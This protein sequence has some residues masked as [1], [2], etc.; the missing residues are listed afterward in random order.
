MENNTKNYITV[1]KDE[2]TRKMTNEIYK[3]FGI[4]TT[5]TLTMAMHILRIA[6]YNLDECSKKDGKK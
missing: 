1:D 4:Y 3:V 6:I 2:F 5:P